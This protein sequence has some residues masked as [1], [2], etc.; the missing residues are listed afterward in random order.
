MQQLVLV[1]HIIFA[2]G[3]IALVLLQHGKGADSGATFGAGGGASQTLFGSQ[4]SASFLSRATAVLVT[5]F[6]ATSLILGQLA[7]SDVKADSLEE[8]LEVVTKRNSPQ[9][10]VKQGSQSGIK[11]PE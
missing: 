3:V 8:L 11:L 7:K 5:L 1:I 4:G 9:S 6:F 10:A 2:L